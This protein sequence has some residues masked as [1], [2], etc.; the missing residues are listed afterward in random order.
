MSVRAENRQELEREGGGIPG[1]QEE[2]VTLSVELPLFFCLP[3]GFSI[4]PISYPFFRRDR[5]AYRQYLYL[6]PSQVG[7]VFYGR[8][9][10][11]GLPS[12]W[13]ICYLLDDK[14]WVADV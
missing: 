3:H 5:P 14:A 1:A 4:M 2:G 6:S 12:P 9:Y 8:A 7:K 13:V 11:L 10:W